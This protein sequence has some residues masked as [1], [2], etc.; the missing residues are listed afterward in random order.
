[1]FEPDFKEWGDV[2]N[3]SEEGD[4]DRVENV[5]PER[6]AQFEVKH[7]DAER[8]SDEH[9]QLVIEGGLEIDILSH[10]LGGFEAG[11]AHNLV[12]VWAQLFVDFF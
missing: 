5:F 2:L 8:V 12:V 6:N 11:R 10:Q 1:M 4:G 9:E 7:E 3:Q